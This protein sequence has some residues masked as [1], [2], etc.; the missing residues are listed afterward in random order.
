MA[1]FQT[2][3]L[4]LDLCVIMILLTY[5][6]Y[7]K[8]NQEQRLR[9]HIKKTVF[10]GETV[11]LH[12]NK[13][14]F[15]D[16]FTWKINSSIIF[17]YDSTNNRSMINFSSNRIHINPAVSKD[18][19]I[20]Q[21]QASDAGNYTCYPAAIRWTL[22]ITENRPASPKQKPLYYTII[23]IS[24]SGVIMF[25]LIITICFCIHRKLRQKIIS[26]S[27]K[28]DMRMISHFDRDTITYCVYSLHTV[29]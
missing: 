9:Q 26:G 8:S 20:H 16:D 7:S 10:V 21:I 15:D 17:S 25:F 1:N 13:T 4:Q 6:D 27:H 23:I 22:T 24:C 5:T 3:N 28:E 19:K 12:C 29:S 2:R 14:P 18:L 11:T